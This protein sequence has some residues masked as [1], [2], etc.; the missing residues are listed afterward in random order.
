MT[1]HNP[2]ANL[3]LAA[4]PEADYIRLEP[5]FE[6]VGIGAGQ[7]I[8]P[9]GTHGRYGYFPVSG[10]VSLV[11][12]SADNEATYIAEIGKEGLIGAWYLLGRADMPFQCLALTAVG[13]YRIPI[14][15][16]KAEMAGNQALSCSLLEYNDLLMI[17]MAQSAICCRRHSAEQK[18]CKLLLASVDRLTSNELELTQQFIANILGLRR[19]E[20]THA[21]RGLQKARL[22]EYNRGRIVVLDRTG[23]ESRA[24]DCYRI[25]RT[26][27]E[28][29]PAAAST[30]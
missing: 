21:A 17:Q 5:R 26:R 3:L 19:E 7:V 12:L 14:D 27:M 25:V 18:L 28:R 29:L 4:L 22:L 15:A 13:A 23:L 6:S 20:I 16:L 11:G 8:N 10:L 2:V 9:S 24:C 1:W 30:G